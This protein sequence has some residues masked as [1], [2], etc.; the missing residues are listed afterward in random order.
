[1]HE[2]IK[3][4]VDAVSRKT[5]KQGDSREEMQLKARD[6]L[7]RALMGFKRLPT[8]VFQRAL[9]KARTNLNLGESFSLKHFQTRLG[10]RR[11]ENLQIWLHEVESH[12]LD[13]WDEELSRDGSGRPAKRPRITED[14]TDDHQTRTCTAPLR[15]ILRPELLNHYDSIVAIADKCQEDITDTIDELSV[16]TLKATMAV[17]T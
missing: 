16:L 5:L 6:D 1:M 10:I 11:D 2:K 14:S 3:T 8:G 15:Q 4:Q 12:F 7:K 9:D 17:S 13:A